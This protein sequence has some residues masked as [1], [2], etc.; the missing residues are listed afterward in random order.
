MKNQI[1]ILNVGSSS[2]KWKL[3]SIR[4]LIELNNN[5]T[6]KL[7]LEKIL[8]KFG[9]DI[10]AI[11]HRIVHGG[12]KYFKPV[13]LTDE[14][15][16]NLQEISH[17]AP[18]HNPPALQ[19]VNRCK[20]LLPAVANFAVFDT[21]F[22]HSLPPKAYLYGLPYKLY[23]KHAIRRYGFHGISHEFVAA[24]AAH[25]LGKPLKEVNLLTLHLGQGASITAIEKGRA[26]DT[27]MGFTPLEGLTMCTRSGDIDPAIIFYLH[28]K[29][30]YS[31]SFIEQLLYSQS[32]TLGISSLSADMR[33]ILASPD[34]KAKLA[35]EVYCYRIRK[36]LGAYLAILNRVNA[37]VFTG[38]IGFGSEKIR[39]LILHDFK[40]VKNVPVITVETNEELAIARKV[41]KIL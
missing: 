30:G 32:G 5:S 4:K 14:A 11:G 33:D 23:Q 20:D 3:F 15:I 37:V 9:P 28:E 1:L 38:A 10:S 29:L 16:K 13:K 27:S 24:E 8:H 35:V 31:L 17:L 18:L 2:F 7:S 6:N 40:L 39:N 25:K 21:G 41:L 26:V 22:Y 19:V 12:E 36:Y 34:P